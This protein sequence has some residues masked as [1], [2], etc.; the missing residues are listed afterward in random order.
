[1]NSSRCYWQPG[2]VHKFISSFVSGVIHKEVCHRFLVR[3]AISQLREG[4]LITSSFS[5]L[6]PSPLYTLSVTASPLNLI[7]GSGRLKPQH[8][9]KCY[10]DPCAGLLPHQR[11]LS[12][13]CRAVIVAV[14]SMALS[15]KGRPLF[16]TIEKII[17]TILFIH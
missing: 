15:M 13:L 5:P 10:Q 2:E 14:K 9:Q 1:M 3:V 11:A 7:I 4:L 6:N 8:F 17:F 12:R 16:V